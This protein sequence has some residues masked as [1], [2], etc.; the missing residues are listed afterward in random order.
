MGPALGIACCVQ[1]G[2]CVRGWGGERTG[3]ERGVVLGQR[4]PLCAP[5][6]LEQ[7]PRR[8]GLCFKSNKLHQHFRDDIWRY[9]H[10]KPRRGWPIAL[11]TRPWELPLPCLRWGDLCQCRALKYHGSSPPPAS[12]YTLHTPRLTDWH[13]L[14]LPQL[15]F[16][17]FSASNVKQSGLFGSFNNPRINPGCQLN[18]GRLE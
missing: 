9:Q 4:G 14:T 16:S 1:E 15:L 8:S 6:T 7:E 2:R 17:S 18:L 5:S 13:G 3:M 10:A 11:P 12:V